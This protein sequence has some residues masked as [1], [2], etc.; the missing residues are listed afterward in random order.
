MGGSAGQPSGFPARRNRLPLLPRLPLA[1]PRPARAP[2]AGPLCSLALVMALPLVTDRLP[3]SDVLH[4]L[5]AA[6]VP[7][8]LKGS[9]A[10]NPATPFRKV[11]MRVENQAFGS[12][13]PAIY[14]ITPE[15]G[16]AHV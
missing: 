12:N 8:G 14:R 4:T 7:G 10:I 13:S 15:I 1:S 3:G 9:S 5:H 2:L 11:T 6:D 16:R